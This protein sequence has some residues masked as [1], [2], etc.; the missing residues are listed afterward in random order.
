MIFEP[1]RSQ[2]APGLYFYELSVA[3]GP[4]VLAAPGA[5]SYGELF[6][7]NWLLEARADLTT[8]FYQD[9]AAGW[10]EATQN[11]P[12]IQSP[13]GRER[14]Y[15]LAFNQTAR[16]IFCYELDGVVKVTRWDPPTN[17]YLQNV[18][19]PGVDPQLLMDAT[20]TKALGDSDVV[21]FYL[22][23]DRTRVMYRLQRETFGVAHELYAH[24]APLVLDRAQAL[25]Y[26]YQLLVSDAS[27]VP[28]QADGV[29]QA[30]RSS[31]YPIWLPMRP[32][33]GEGRFTGGLYRETAFIR[34]HSFGLRGSGRFT[35]GVYF[36]PVVLYSPAPFG[37]R[38][39]GRFSSGVYKSIVTTYKPKSFA[40]RGS[41]KFSSG[42]YKNVVKGT[43]N[44]EIRVRGSGRFTG[45][46]Y[47]AA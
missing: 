17:S 18:T 38:G 23:P 1:R 37:V 42:L 31:L 15:S 6:G 12:F 4:L 26:R 8:R 3:Q 46:S 16:V 14:R 28:L 34:A 25:L 19:F 36:M 33:R 5:G 35:G 10:V 22:S 45:G 20:I 21:L 11:L 9:T 24:T 41:G 47:A 39:Q 30:L 43:A 2:R 40:V 32:L 27:G 13:T 7:T 29:T 44:R